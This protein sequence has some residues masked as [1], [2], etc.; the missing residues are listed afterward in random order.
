MLTTKPTPEMIAEWQSVFKAYRPHLVP[1]KKSIHQVIAYLR[2]KYPLEVVDTS[3]ALAVVTN[4]I[5]MN[6]PFAEK[7]PPGRDLRPVVFTIPNRDGGTVLYEK[8]EALFQGCPIMVGLEYE[9]AYVAV[10]GCGEL[11][12]EL[13][14]FQGLDETDLKNYYLVANYVACL[15]KNALKAP[16][17][18]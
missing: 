1:N 7:I 13:V 8:Q 4:N 10:E 17:S 5:T 2:Q 16:G 15:K 11:A 3:E 9:T 12:D 14:A 6:R 18:I